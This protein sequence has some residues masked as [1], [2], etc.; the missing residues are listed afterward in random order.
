MLDFFKSR[1]LIGLD[2]GSHT[3]KVVQLQKKGERQRLESLASMQIASE[4]QEEADPALRNEMLA[5]AIKSV[6]K[7]NKIT[8]KNVVS[9]IAGDSVIVR[10][11]KLPLMSEEELKN[12]ISLEAEQYIPLAIDQVVLDFFILGEVEEEGIQKIEVLLVAAKEEIIDM[13]VQLLR[14]VGLNPIAIEVDTFALQNSYKLNYG[15]NEGETICLINIGAKLTTINVLE[16]GVTHLTRDVA[17]AGNNFTREIQRE[18]DIT[19]ADA[20]AL[21]KTDGKVL[22]ESE[23]IMQM[24]IP[25]EDDNA[26]RIGEAITPVLNKLVAEIQRSFDYYESS[27]RKKSISRIV[28]SGGSG[29][30]RSL[31]KYLADK[32]D[33]AVEINDPFREII[34]PDKEFDHEFIFE[35]AQKFNIGVGLALR[36]ME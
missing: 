32:F 24:S 13:H 8:C 4:I 19:F 25:K 3:V 27:I 31:D 5:E 9:S 14:L 10:Y 15:L 6:L 28:L 16:D 33:M 23:D 1:K 36:Q 34:I 17:V 30:L 18:F 12:V 11:V 29:K 35:Q 2:I 7:E 22:I 26:A 20:E 21:K